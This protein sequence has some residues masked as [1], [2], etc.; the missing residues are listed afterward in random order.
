MFHSYETNM[1]VVYSVV[2][3]VPLYPRQFNTFEGLVKFGEPR[4]PTS[5]FGR[6]IRDITSSSVSTPKCN[7]LT[8]RISANLSSVTDSQCR[9]HCPGSKSSSPMRNSLSTVLVVKKRTGIGDEFLPSQ[10]S[11]FSYSL[12]PGHGPSTRP[13]GFDNFRG[14]V[15]VIQCKDSFS[16]PPQSVRQKDYFPE[17]GTSSEGER[18]VTMTQNSQEGTYYHPIVI[19]TKGA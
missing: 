9:G 11:V 18:C 14:K 3:F 1:S 12:D 8:S 5:G 4:L 6:K 19:Y 15:N 16:S 17:L 10:V 7:K 13:H 2:R